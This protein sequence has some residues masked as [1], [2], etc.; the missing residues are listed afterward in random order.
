[1]L[2]IGLTGGIASG[3]STVAAMLRD[4]DY[5]VL[6]ADAI[7]REL[8][9][10]GQP[11]HDE[12]VRDFGKGIAGPGGAIDRKK[13]AAIVFSDSQQLE[14]L[15]QILHPRIRDI[16]EN[17]F[18]AL[19]RPGGPDLAFEDAALIL[20]A[21]LKDKFDRVIVCWCWPEQQVERLLERGMSAEDAQ[22]R[23]AAQMPIDQKRVLADEVIDCSGTMRETEQ[24]VERLLEKL[25]KAA[26]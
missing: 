24:Q 6:D 18:K 13:L 19:N 9:E 4:R 2:R 16:T 26:A 7:A 8:L 21:G 11:A 5:P 23:I 12:V 20:E 17:F 22:K 15:N 10:P 14:R 1:M 3:K 25:K